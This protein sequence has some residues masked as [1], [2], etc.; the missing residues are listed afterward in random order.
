MTNEIKKTNPSSL[1]TDPAHELTSLSPDQQKEL[2][3]LAQLA[4]IEAQLQSQGINTRRIPKQTTLS[5]EQKRSTQKKL[6]DFKE[7]LQGKLP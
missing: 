3:Q 7:I 1:P 2:A 6:T 4:L 5:P